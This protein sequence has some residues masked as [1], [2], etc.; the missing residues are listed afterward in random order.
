MRLFRRTPRC[1]ACRWPIDLTRHYWKRGKMMWHGGLN[2]YPEIDPP[3]TDELAIRLARAR[4]EG[5]VDPLDRGA[6][7][8][9]GG[10][11]R[12]NPTNHVHSWFNGQPTDPPMFGEPSQFKGTRDCDELCGS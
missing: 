9:A 7:W 8:L 2:C 12:G 10:T 6:W 3:M 1:R 11:D 5:P 4:R